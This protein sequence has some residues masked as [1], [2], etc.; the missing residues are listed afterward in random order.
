MATPTRR[1]RSSSSCVSEASSRWWR[2]L[3]LGYSESPGRWLAFKD[4]TTICNSVPS[5][6][7]AVI[8]LRARASIVARNL[9]IIAANL[10][11]AEPF[12]S[13]RSFAWAPP[14]AGSVAFPR[15]L[16]APL[17][18]VCARALE[19]GLMILTGRQ[20]DFD[21][22]HLRVGLGAAAFPTRSPSWLR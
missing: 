8:A 11:E 19:R 5:E 20:F 6:V 12:F 13:T 9:A 10:A 21:R 3:K 1:R 7:L 2:D 22:Q 4:Y 14:Q 15:W 16:G 17:D 18:D